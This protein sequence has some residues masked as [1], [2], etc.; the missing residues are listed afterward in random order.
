MAITFYTIL[1]VVGGDDVI[2][3]TFQVPLEYQVWATSLTATT[4]CPHRCCGRE[5]EQ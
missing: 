2:G 5:G 3:I 1:L 4:R